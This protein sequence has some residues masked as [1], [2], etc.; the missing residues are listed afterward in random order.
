[1]EAAQPDRPTQQPT[2][3]KRRR[4]GRS[5]RQSLRAA[6]LAEDTRPVRP[7][8]ESQR[9][10]A[11]TEAEQARVHAAVLDVLEN[12]GLADAIPSCIEAVEAMGGFM[13]DKGRLCFPA[14]LVEDAIANANRDV[15]L[16]GQKSEHDV[17]PR[18]KRVYFGTA[19]AAV[20]IVDP[21]TGEY[22][23]ST[24][25]DL[26]DI[27]RLVDTLD[28]VHFFQ[29]PVVARDMESGR[30]LDLNTT[31][32]GVSGTTKHLGTSFVSPESV[33]ESLAMLHMIAGGEARW[34]ARPFVSQSNCF[35]VPPLK[36]AQDACRCLEAAVAGGMP[37]L[38]LS[39]GQAG[40]TGPAALAGTLVQAMAEVLAGLV[41]VNALKPK[42]AAMIGPWPFVSDLR[43]GAM[44]GG[45]GEQALLMSACGT[46]GRFY[47]LPTGVASAM[48]DS[49]VPDAQAGAEKGYNHALIGNSGANLIYESA[50]MHGSLLGFCLESLVIDNDV[51]GAVQRTIRGIEIDERT[52]A[53]EVIR[54]VCEE[55]P[56]HYLGHGQTLRRME[57]DYVYPEVGNRLSPQEWAASGS[58]NVLD[59]ALVKTRERLQTHFPGHI[60]GDMDARIRADFDIRLPREAMAPDQNIQGGTET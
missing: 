9:Y 60:S 37:V 51:I 54:E 4:G 50:G 44:S 18:G 40:A 30:L 1:M 39:A 47:D 48:T 33:D 57:T 28:H 20:H 52:L 29:R 35:V 42:A 46:M 17:E 53:R 19:G 15:V 23:D 16:Y 38:L 8:M 45:S 21:V 31:Y 6:P 59:T 14:A 22:R 36:F 11:L 2:A 27:A 43:T 32:A 34:R 49:K 12:I 24:L 10:Q 7:G 25:R 56:G 58:P 5:A 3:G 41:Y 55:G 13:N 26:Y